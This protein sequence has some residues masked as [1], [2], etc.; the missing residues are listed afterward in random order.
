MVWLSVPREWSLRQG[1]GAGVDVGGEPQK[2]G[3]VSEEVR[4]G[5]ER[6]VQGHL[7]SFCLVPPA[8]LRRVQD[9]SVQNLLPER[10]RRGPLH[11]VLASVMRACPGALTLRGACSLALWTA[12]PSEKTLGQRRASARGR[13]KQSQAAL[14]VDWG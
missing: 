1:L 2:Q 9:A 11:W 13:G 5:K 14:S 12:L 3:R 7:A 8:L 4:M 10:W 6:Q